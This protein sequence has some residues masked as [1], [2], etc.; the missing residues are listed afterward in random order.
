MPDN[1]TP[2]PGSAPA[3]AGQPNAGN[4]PAASGDA[5]KGAPDATIL[6]ARLEA[7]E[8]ALKQRDDQILN[9]RSLHDRQMNELRA[10]LRGRPASAGAG[11]TR[12][13]A[14]TAETEPDDTYYE[15]PASR[16][17]EAVDPA[18]E[19]D[20]ALIKF[21]Q[22]HPDWNEY[23]NDMAPVL[24]DPTK[25]AP[26]AIIGANGRVD[27]YRSIVYLKDTLERD[28]LRKMKA[29]FDQARATAGDTRAAL[30]T[31]AVISGQGAAT[32]E[33]PDF[34]KMDQKEKMQWLYKNMPE[35]FDPDDLP[36][37][38]REG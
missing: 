33:T 27:Y 13:V 22:L 9:L 6:A 12:D 11:R 32:V 35:L 30:K 28:R 19:Q 17:T 16:G 14:P 31:D 21:R 15:A 10:S 34:S 2:T 20:I 37:S 4:A 7:V 24:S 23:W 29:E 18:L 26:F 3:G 38:L 5:G 1:V 36:S 8:R 25:A